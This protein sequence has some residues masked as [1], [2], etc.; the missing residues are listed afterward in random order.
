MIDSQLLRDLRRRFPD[1]SAE[2]RTA[3]LL[4]GRQ[5]VPSLWVS[6]GPAP[7]GAWE[8]L[9]R[10]HAR[11]GLWPLLLAPGNDVPH[12]EARDL[13]LEPGEPG[14]PGGSGEP[15]GPGE[16]R[17]D[18]YDV[19]ALLR[20]WWEKSLLWCP[21]GDPQDRADLLEALAPYGDTWPGPAPALVPQRDPQECA[22]RLARQLLRARPSLRIGLVRADGGA[23][24]LAACG[25]NGTNGHGDSGEIAAVLHGWQQRFGA[26]LV[27]VGAA[28]VELS[29]AAPPTS[30]A[31]ALLV[32]AEHA[33]FC[34]DNVLGAEEGLAGYAEDLVDAAHWGFWWD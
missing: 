32:A 31:E 21:S 17:A 22:D 25:W 12:L 9:R 20:E 33:A 6:D 1:R 34:P 2:G 28:S 29:V 4:P 16:F 14:E 8:R 13:G 24:A 19:A 18:R 26:R 30:R 23:Q 5:V 7:Q 15:G 10:E 3:P 11:S 27:E